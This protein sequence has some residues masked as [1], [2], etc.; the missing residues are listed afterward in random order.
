[1]AFA[2]LALLVV[3]GS[4]FLGGRLSS[5]STSPLFRRLTFR[6]GNIPSARFGVDSKTVVYSAAWDGGPARAFFDPVG[7]F[8]IPLARIGSGYASRDFH[9]RPDGDRARSSA[10][11]GGIPFYRGTLAEAPL[12]GGAARDLLNDVLAADWD[13]LGKKVAVARMAGDHCRLE[14]PLGRVLYESKGFISD[15]RISPKQDLIAFLDH[16]DC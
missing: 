16:P 5:H 1:M 4:G 8:P 13:S 3:I 15:V 14:F 11:P 7:L 6:R 9:D 12:A 10:L 2:A